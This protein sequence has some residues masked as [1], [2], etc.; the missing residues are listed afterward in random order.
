[1]DTKLLNVA[2]FTT[3]KF[4]CFVTNC[5]VREQEHQLNSI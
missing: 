2:K 1:M 4:A 5:V 3:L